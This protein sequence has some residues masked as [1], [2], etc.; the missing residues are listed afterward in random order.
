VNFGRRNREARTRGSDDLAVVQSAEGSD[1]QVIRRSDDAGL[2]ILR[3][4]EA[5]APPSPPA[6]GEPLQPGTEQPAG[7]LPRSARVRAFLDPRTA[8]RRFRHFRR[9]RP[10]WAAVWVLLGGAIVTYWPSTAYRF[11]FA[12]A[13]VTEG[14]AV[15]IVIVVLGV[16]VLFTRA[17]SLRK[18]YSVLIVL[19]AVASLITSDVGGFLFGMV[20]SMIGGAMA[21]AWVP[22]A[23]ASRRQRRRA[24]RS[25]TDVAPAA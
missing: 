16:F 24:K 9:S 5:V 7:P 19:A 13:S 15:G 2:G 3:L 6:G 10:F 25:E 8:R 4:P 14:M 18:F 1:P 22:L 21:F 12:S 17:D 11:V 20:F 23:P